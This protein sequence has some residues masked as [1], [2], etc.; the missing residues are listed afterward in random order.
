MYKQTTISP[1]G[2]MATRTIG[3]RLMIELLV[4]MHLLKQSGEDIEI[5]TNATAGN[6][7][8]WNKLTVIR[9]NKNSCTSITNIFE[10]T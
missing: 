4:Q 2:R 6:A 7:W 9:K 8:D 10:K 5:Q 3:D 1:D